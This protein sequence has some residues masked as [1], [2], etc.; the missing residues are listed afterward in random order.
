MKIAAYFPLIFL[1]PEPQLAFQGWAQPGATVTSGPRPGPHRGRGSGLPPLPVASFVQE[2]GSEIIS[3]LPP[4]TRVFP[5]ISWVFVTRKEARKIFS[6]IGDHVE[7]SALG[8]LIMAAS[9][10]PMVVRLLNEFVRRLVGVPDRRDYETTKTYHIARHIGQALAGAA[11]FLFL[12]ILSTVLQ[13]GLSVPITSPFVKT[14]SSDFNV[15][16][17]TIHSMFRFRWCK[18]ALLKKFL[19]TKPYEIINFCKIVTNLALYVVTSI[20][21]TEQLSE[22][23][24]KK[25]GKYLSALL[26]F[27]GVGTIAF[28]LASKDLAAKVI[29]GLQLL[30]LSPFKSG[31][32][33]HSKDGILG[34]VEK[35][36]L[37]STSVRGNDEI[38]VDI[39]NSLIDNQT[40]MNL[41][42]AQKSQVKQTIRY[43]YDSID[44]IPDLVKSIK[45]EIELTCPELITDG[46][47]PFRVHWDAFEKGCL[48][49][50][51]D[52]RFRIPP[53]TDAY[54]DN[55]QSMLEA[56]AKASKKC[57]VTYA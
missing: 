43:K 57:G 2:V 17:F 24:S 32:D 26:G 20:M 21:I 34:T 8:V 28:S 13:K 45:S 49:I 47:R 54:Y 15:V 5:F 56:I 3:E 39:P 44:K 14:M 25:S 55:R 29:S 40:I 30:L 4:L 51:I 53:G 18:N 11:A 46:S 31:D 6:A 35:Q 12:E 33:I 16:Y 36:N 10:L 38:S 22:T 7:I 23:L 52:C 37:F 19:R 9:L 1:F 50:S 41:S 27:G 48:D 42:R